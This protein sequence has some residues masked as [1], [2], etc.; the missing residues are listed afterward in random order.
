MLHPDPLVH[1]GGRREKHTSLET[2]GDATFD[3]AVDGAVERP[4]LARLDL[5][6]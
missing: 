2:F 4:Q 1:E 3:P 6:S 5:R